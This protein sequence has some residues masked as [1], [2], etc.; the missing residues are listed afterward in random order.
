MAEVYSIDSG[1]GALSAATAKTLIEISTPSTQT[2]RIVDITVG[3][4][5][6][7]AGNLKVELIDATSGTGTAYTP[8]KVNGDAQ[9]RAANTTAKVLDSVE[10]SSVTVLKTWMFPLPLGGFEIQ[11]PL[12][13]EHYVPVSK[14]YGI[15]LTSSI[16]SVNG[17]ASVQ[18]EE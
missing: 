3:C 13:R 4:D 15:R 10:P 5:S 18:I 1:S 2:D 14:M 17:Y 7:S 9:N 8:K 11:L 12:G 16:G 6:T